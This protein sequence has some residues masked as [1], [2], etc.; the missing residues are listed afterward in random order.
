ML[1]LTPQQ[2]L[3]LIIK[4]IDFR[5]GMD[6]LA[7]FCRLVLNVSPNDGTLFVFVNKQ[8]TAVKILVYD[9]QGYWLCIKRFSA[10]KLKWWPTCSQDAYLID[11]KKLQVLL[12]QGNPMQADIPADRCR[13]N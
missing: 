8:R 11:A 10:G 3:V 13:V 4:P 5:K 2:R 1:Q 9:G 6:S 7:A 12:Y